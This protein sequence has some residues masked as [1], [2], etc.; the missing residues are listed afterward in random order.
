MTTARPADPRVLL[1]DVA[2]EQLKRLILD[3]TLAPG[4]F[5]S[6]RELTGILHM[7]KTPIRAALERLALEGFV[8]VSPQRGIMV[9]EM[10]LQEIVDHY[11]LRLALETFVVARLAGRLDDEQRE[12]LRD[13]LRRQATCVHDGDAAAY[14]AAD[15]D[16]HHQLCVF[17]GN[18][19]IVD[20]MRLQREK[21]SRVG[22]QISRRDPGRMRVSAAEHAAIVAAIEAGDAELAAA[23]AAEHLENGKR[24]LVAGATR[25][26][27]LAPATRRVLPAGLGG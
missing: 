14:I 8:H 4:R 15:G 24:F 25:G 22:T 7:S 19:Q 27:Q 12:V 6:E 16:F 23:R 17:D 2:L 20:V 5:V 9:L 21:L 11:D 10:S 18:Q 13:H 3:G 1:K 26:L